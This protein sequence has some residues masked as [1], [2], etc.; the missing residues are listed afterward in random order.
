MDS[1]EGVLQTINAV[2]DFVTQSKELLD[3]IERST[4]YE[5][6]QLDLAHERYTLSF[7]H[8]YACLARLLNALDTNPVRMAVT[9]ASSENHLKLLDILRALT[10]APILDNWPGTNAA[11]L[12]DA[13]SFLQQQSS[14]SAVAEHISNFVNGRPSPIPLPSDYDGPHK[15]FTYKDARALC[16]RLLATLAVQRAM[17]LPIRPAS[18]VSSVHE[19]HPTEP[20]EQEIE[21][22]AK[23]VL[24]VDP[25][26]KYA[27]VTP[28]KPEPAP[29]VSEQNTPEIVENIAS[30]IGI[31]DQVIKPLGGT[32]NFLQVSFTA[33]Y[34]FRSCGYLN[35][36]T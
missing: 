17:G 30:D 29:A 5:E 12:S 19:E 2:Q 11:A 15:K 1:Y 32:F 26:M 3:D 20:T 4:K 21:H 13:P 35:V 16:F 10:T 9:R 34:P 14:L 31:I 8:T 33:L 28:S 18:A 23:A 24:S 25:A 36:W 27:Q 6:S 22:P 7:L